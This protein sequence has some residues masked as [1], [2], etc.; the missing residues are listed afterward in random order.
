MSEYRDREKVR[1]DARYD[2]EY[3]G[4]RAH[5]PGRDSDS[6]VRR[7]YES[8]YCYQR[9]RLEDEE[10]DRQQQARSAREEYDRQ[11]NWEQQAEE[12][13]ERQDEEQPQSRP[14]AADAPR[15]GSGE[16]CKPNSPA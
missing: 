11:C 9:N 14:G 8:E 12:E 16:A 4:F 1:S 5:E 10:R 3:S 2:A 13:A 6:D 15:A 7:E